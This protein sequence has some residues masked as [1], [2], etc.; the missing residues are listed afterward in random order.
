[1]R[2]VVWSLALSLFV[3]ASGD[4]RSGRPPAT[5]AR[6]DVAAALGALEFVP[7]VG[8][9]D[10]RVRFAALGDTL[11]WLHD[12]GYTLQLQRWVAREHD[13]VRGE[14]EQLGCVVRAR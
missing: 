7:N 4:H 14:R 2:P 11:G 13:D 3:A 6:G 9:W 5:A 8:Q 12:D 1:M 10:T